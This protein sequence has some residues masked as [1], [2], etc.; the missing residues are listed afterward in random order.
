M[1]VEFDWKAEISRVVYWKQIAAEHDKQSA[2]PWHLPRVGAS[3]ENIRLAEIAIGKS[4]SPQYKKF[5][6]HADGWQ[7][8]YLL[9]D[10]FG[11]KEIINGSSTSALDRTELLLF[12]E[13]IGV[14]KDEVIPIG[15]SEYD[16]DVFLLVS[17]TSKVLPEG[18][19]WVAG[20]EI[21][22]YQSFSEFF[23][24]MVN[25]NARIAKN[26]VSE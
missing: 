26:L 20:E 11:T 7:S 1:P 16:L 23:S 22:R 4:F 10:L 5:L 19:L 15:A 17:S 9:V 13:S 21:D 14:N 18:V 8:F 25:Y 12:L 24:A 6:E 2:L 3:P